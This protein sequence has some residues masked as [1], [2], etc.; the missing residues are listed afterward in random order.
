MAAP[1]ATGGFD[2][3]RYKQTTEQQWQTA[4][5]AWND[6]GGLL[7][8]WLGPATET[9]IEMCGIGPGARVLDVAAGAGDQTLQ[10][11]QRVGSTGYVLATDI[12]SNILEYA[13]RNAR[14]GGYTNVATRVMDGENLDVPPA[15]FDAVVSRVGL[16]YFPDQVRALRGMHQALRPGGRVGAIVYSSPDA[17]PFFSIPVSIIRARARLPP[18]VPGQ[19]GPFSLGTPAAIEE[20]FRS[21]GF[22][23]VQVRRVTAPLRLGSAADCVRFEQESFGALH[24]MMSTVSP[25]ERTAIWEEIHA[26]LAAFENGGGFVGPCELLVASALK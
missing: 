17:N 9:M 6:W 1:S 20:R 11:A 2:P 26:R 15:S 10:V 22:R 4:A 8:E 3:S 14:A 7:R 12:S 25:E 23:D 18:P 19:P 13:D 21:A 24:A 16:I 5:K